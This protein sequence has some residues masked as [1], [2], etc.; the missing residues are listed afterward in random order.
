MF[1]EMSDTRSSSYPFMNIT[2][3]GVHGAISLYRLVDSWV[4]RSLTMFFLIIFLVFV[5][6][7][8][9]LIIALLLRW[10]IFLIIFFIVLSLIL[11]LS[12]W[13]CLI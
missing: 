4:R 3:D 12:W 9:P 10:L 1:T 6:V 11:I 2:E 13:R 8:S 7:I 5:M